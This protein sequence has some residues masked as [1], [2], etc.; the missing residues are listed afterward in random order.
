MSLW[1]QDGIRLHHLLEAFSSGLASE[2]QQPSL[3]G[4]PQA[5][6]AL[7]LAYTAQMLLYDAH[8]CANFDQLGGV[9][10]QEQLELQAVAMAG[11]RTV[12]PAISRF[13]MVVRAALQAGDAMASNP[14]LLSCMY[15]AGKYYFWYYRE[16]RRVGLLAEA[17]EIMLTL[18]ALAT[19]W[20][21]AGHYVSI[22]EGDEFRPD[23]QV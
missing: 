11:L 10:I 5:Y 1:Y 13:A 3:S 12:C 16:T 8:T 15:E 21:L 14:L 22:L 4:E 17:N 18:R 20:P 2:L 7:G 23:P 6:P 19:G 9:G